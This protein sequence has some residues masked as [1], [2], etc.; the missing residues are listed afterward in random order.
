MKRKTQYLND[1]DSV[2]FEET[3]ELWAGEARAFLQAQVIELLNAGKP[4][5]A[6]KLFRNYSDASLKAAKF[7]IDLAADVAASHQSHQ[8]DTQ[9]LEVALDNAEERERVLANNR[10]RLEREL[11]EARRKHEEVAQDLREK[12]NQA[13]S[14]WNLSRAVTDEWRAKA[15]E[16]REKCEA[17]HRELDQALTRAERAEDSASQG[18]EFS[19]SLETIILAMHNGQLGHLSR[20]LQDI[21]R[22]IVAPNLEE[23]VEGDSDDNDVSF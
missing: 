13:L 21:Q 14:D 11:S 22:N 23:P 18:W 20:A 19:H 1:N 8:S 3:K 16:W 9:D 12:L 15:E 7:A 4:I 6:I 2:I 17:A 5:Q 10:D